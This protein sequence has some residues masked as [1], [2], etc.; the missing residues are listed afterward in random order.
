[1]Q[2]P[3]E[4]LRNSWRKPAQCAPA[5]GR[6]DPTTG[7]IDEPVAADPP[8]DTPHGSP[9]D[10]RHAIPLVYAPR[11]K[12]IAWAGAGVGVALLAAVLVAALGQVYALN[13]R[14]AAS[15]QHSAELQKTVT[16]L[17]AA[18]ATSAT[19]L[20]KAR[21]DTKD[22]AQAAAT[23]TQLRDSVEAFAKQAASC[24]AVKRRLGQLGRLGA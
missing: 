22:L 3:F 7:V 11:R 4:R 19:E 5:G 2:I 12:W 10:S 6:I 13:Q 1:M 14:L 15:D 20:A 16:Q 21:G 8:Q 9:D 17:K 18:N 23:S 24:D